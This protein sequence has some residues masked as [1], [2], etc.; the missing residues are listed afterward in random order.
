MKFVLKKSYI[1]F[2]IALILVGIGVGIYFYNSNKNSSKGTADYN[3]Q[4]LSSTD[5]QS[6]N[7]TSNENNETNTENNNSNVENETNT[8]NNNTSQETQ[9]SSFSTKIYSKDSDRQN[10]VSL[11]CSALNETIVNP[12]DTFSFCNTVGRATESKGYEKADTFQDGEVIQAL[13]G[14]KCQVSST[15][16]NAVLQIPELTVTERHEHS[17]SVPYVS[18]GKDAAVSYRQ[19]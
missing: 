15:L 11:T 5:N 17:N 12:G 4:K 18:K 19:L 10:N 7:S 6:S 16:Y 8:Q 13:G 2:I 9:I 14:G 3:S 1:F